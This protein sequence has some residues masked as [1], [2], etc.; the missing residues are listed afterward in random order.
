MSDS[1]TYRPAIPEDAVLIDLRPEDAAEVVL[2]GVPQEEALEFTIRNSR[3]AWTFEDSLGRVVA[4]FGMSAKEGL[5]HPWLVCSPLVTD[6]ARDVV[7]L[8]RS[9]AALWRTQPALVCNYISKDAAG[10]R[11]FIQRLGFRIVPSPVGP[12]DFFYLPPA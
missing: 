3:Q 11:A 12:F 7:G 5:I 9:L 4:L 1:L 8:G 2:Y 10:A 6:H